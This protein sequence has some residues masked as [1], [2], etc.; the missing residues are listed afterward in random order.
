MSGRPERF[1]GGFGVMRV[2]S[3][4]TEPPGFGVVFSSQATS[5]TLSGFA[6]VRIPVGSRLFVRPEFEVSR[7]GE[8][9]RIGGTVAIGV[10]W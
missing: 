3:S 1:G 6:G 8:H 2:E 9:M 5:G 4:R 7:G 10:G